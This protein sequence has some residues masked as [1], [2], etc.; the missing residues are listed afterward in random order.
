MMAVPFFVVHTEHSHS[1]FL[2]HD[3]QRKHFFAGQLKQEQ[4]IQFLLKTLLSPQKES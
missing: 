4:S 1:S 3:L 2:G